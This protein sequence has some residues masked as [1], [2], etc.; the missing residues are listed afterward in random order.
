MTNSNIKLVVTNLLGATISYEPETP[1]MARTIVS[2]AM[3]GF[4][5]ISGLSKDKEYEMRILIEVK[6]QPK[7]V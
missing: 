3:K 2:N 1:E 7:S 4:E 6:E 5:A